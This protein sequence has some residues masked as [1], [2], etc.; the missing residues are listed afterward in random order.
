MFVWF[1][2]LT[3][4]AE[5]VA[6]EEDRRAEENCKKERFVLEKEANLWENWRKKLRFLL[7]PE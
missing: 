6:W 4:P 1:V 5:L 7:S 3:E 2:R